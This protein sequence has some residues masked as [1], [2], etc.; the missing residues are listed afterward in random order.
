MQDLVNTP[1]ADT[2][3]QC[4]AMYERPE[5]SGQCEREELYLRLNN[6]EPQQR[7]R[8]LA[9]QLSFGVG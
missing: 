9:L 4:D 6:P 3:V 1:A 2:G 7:P 5:A 8:C